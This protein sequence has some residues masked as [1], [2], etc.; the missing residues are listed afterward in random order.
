MSASI[1]DGGPAFPCESYGIKNG[2][3]TTVPAQG[4]TVRDYFA[5]QALAGILMNHTT[6]KFGLTEISVAC[7]AYKFADAMLAAKE[8]SK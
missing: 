8:A 3:E 2:K 7:Y 1:N 4:M 6:A 5:G